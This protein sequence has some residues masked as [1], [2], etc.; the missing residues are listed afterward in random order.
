MDSSA[1]SKVKI[2]YSKWAET[3]EEDKIELFKKNGIDYDEFMNKFLECCELK[4]NIDIL[5]IGIGTGLTSIFLAK[6][7]NN[8]CK[9]TGIEPSEEMIKI[10][11]SNLKKEELEDVINIKK[12]LGEEIPFDD[13][14]FDLTV[15]TFALRHMEIEKALNEM[16]RVLKNKG[17]AV[18]ADICAP[19]KWRT[20]FGKIISFVAKYIISGK[21]KHKGESKS[22]V[23]T[24]KEWKGLF[25]EFEFKLN[26]ILEFSSKKDPE[27]KPKRV[28]FSVTKG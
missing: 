12:G 9:I 11:K 6:K 2:Q 5:D 7:M 1:I 14:S 3:Y 13:G 15:S 16:K 28:I 17:R 18:I 21:K 20:G 4:P 25:D 10:A 27:W 26:R 19:E 8:K 24:V 22:R 23:L